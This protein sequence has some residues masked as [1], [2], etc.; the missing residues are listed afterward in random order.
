MNICRKSFSYF[1]LFFLLVGFFSPINETFAKSIYKQ[2]V[3]TFKNSSNIELYYLKTT[4]KWVSSAP[5]SVVTDC[6]ASKPLK[7]GDRCSVILTSKD[8]D[9]GHNGGGYVFFHNK[10]LS[11]IV[12]IY[13]HTYTKGSRKVKNVCEIFVNGNKVAECQVKQRSDGYNFLPDITAAELK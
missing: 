3:V 7:H 6:M 8:T 13:F 10:A 9:Y 5:N 2:A 1:F 12:K 11:K 4:S